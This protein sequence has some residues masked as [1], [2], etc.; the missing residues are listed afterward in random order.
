M[1]LRRI[2]RPA[3]AAFALAACADEPATAPDAPSYST[4]GGVRAVVV[5]NDASV[6][7]DGVARIQS[8][9]GTVNRSLD[10]IGVV[11]A[12]LSPDALATLAADPAV[13]TVGTDR[14][15]NWLPGVRLAGTLAADPLAKPQPPTDPTK[16]G[17][18]AYQWNM[19]VIGADKAWAAGYFGA[20]YVKVAILDTGIDYTNRELTGLV[21]MER[22]T[23]F[24]PANAGLPGDAPFMDDHFHG[25]HVA[26]SVVTNHVTVAGVAPYTSLVAVKVLSAAGY[27]LFEW[28]TAGIVH[29]ADAG[30][31]VLNMSLGAELDERADA[32]LIETL[33]RAV[34]YAE[35]KNAIVISAA[36]NDAMNIDAP[37]V[38]Y[39]PCEVS[40]ICVSATGPLMQQ[41][42]DQPATYTNFGVNAIDYAA[43]GG[44]A[45]D[46]EPYVNQ[47]L[48]LGACSTRASDGTLVVCRTSGGPAG[49][50]YVY[51]AGTSMATPHVSG[52]AAMILAKNPNIGVKTLVNKIQSGAEDLGP[53]GPDDFYG[54]GRVNVYRSLTN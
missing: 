2:A 18:W 1:N 49:Y 11:F 30:A 5:Y 32:A 31:N 50:F 44:N 15:V 51:A 54:R 47:D 12:T 10:G 6:P 24:V 28:I 3:V 36:G 39:A 41:N 35:S 40:T 34:K 19:R 46:T 48:I 26:S 38:F 33:R 45:S 22:S 17:R 8:L 29:A 4:D 13:Q 20:P 9:G 21:D 16:V 7:S 52:V 42:F 23:S 14:S 27:G 25:T 37:N 43:P 53:A